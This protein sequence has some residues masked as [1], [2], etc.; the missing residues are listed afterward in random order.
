M[1]GDLYRQHLS[2]CRWV[3][4]WG[5]CLGDGPSQHAQHALAACRVTHGWVALQAG[6]DGAPVQQHVVLRDAVL[7]DLEAMQWKRHAALP[8]KRC[9]HTA[10]APHPSSELAWP[11]GMRFGTSLF[12]DLP[13]LALSMSNCG[14]PAQSDRQGCLLQVPQIHCFLALTFASRCKSARSE[15]QGVEAFACVT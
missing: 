7:L 12:D 6:P 1:T 14:F 15:W 9:S 5:I 8:F 4:G 3:V 11:R 2:D 13:T 10:E